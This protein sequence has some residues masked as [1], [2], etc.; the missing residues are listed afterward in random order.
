MLPQ[1][2]SKYFKNTILSLDIVVDIIRINYFFHLKSSPEKKKK[3]LR[4]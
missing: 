2:R 1:I 4:L 3:N